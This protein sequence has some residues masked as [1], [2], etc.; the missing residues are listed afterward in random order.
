[1]CE[2]CYIQYGRP[3]VVNVKVQM[4]VKLLESL[5]EI[6]PA[7]G[8]A[9]IVADDWN[10]EDEHIQTCITG[11]MHPSWTPEESGRAIVF[12]AVMHCLS[13]DERATVLALHDGLLD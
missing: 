9:H 7:G 6:S 4:T 1:M 2:G 11:C 3:R 8:P 12:L 13:M 10:I 5:Y